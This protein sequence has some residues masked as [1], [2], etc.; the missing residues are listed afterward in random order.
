MENTFVLDV[1]MEEEDDSF[2]K[3]MKEYLQ[4]E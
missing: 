1:K 2:L 4:M 3:E